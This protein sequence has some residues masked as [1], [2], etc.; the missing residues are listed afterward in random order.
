MPKI[1]IREK[2]NSTAP[3]TASNNFSVVVPG[4]KGNGTYVPVDSSDKGPAYLGYGV[5]ELKSQADF[6]KYIGTYTANYEASGTTVTAPELTVLNGTATGLNKYIKQLTLE[7]FE[8]DLIES[9]GYVYRLTEI[10]SGD[11]LGKNGYLL[12]TVGEKTYE[13]TKVEKASDITDFTVIDPDAGDDFVQTTGAYCKIKPGKEG[14]DAFNEDPHYGNQI[15]YNL[16]GYGYTVLFKVLDSSRSAT[17]QLTESEF[18]APL[19][20]KSVFNFRYLIS[21][22]SYSKDV[23]NQMIQ[24]A[25]FDSTVDL[26]DAEIIGGS[27]TG[28]GDCIALCDID[29]TNIN[30]ADSMENI[31]RGLATAAGAIQASSNA[32]IF[33]PKVQYA[34]DDL[35]YPASYHYLLCSANARKRYAEW[36]AVAGYARGISPI[37]VAGTSLK[38]GEI[39]INT[40][41]PRVK[42]DGLNI[43][44]SINLILN[45]KSSY[46]LWG[47]R[48]AATLD[49]VG[50]VFSHFLNVR[51]LCTSIKKTLYSACRLFTFDPNSDLLWIN[52]VNAIRPTL[53]AMK[54][55]QGIKGY[56]ISKVVHNEKALLK[57][58]IRII[59]I[60]AVEDFDITIYLEDSENGLQV[61]AG[62]Q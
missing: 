8:A 58:K 19:K 39:A 62:E 57:A 33:A 43:Q 52:F 5:Y 18:W 4:Y 60:E 7:D 45:E 38:L 35:V 1:L 26:K 41:A 12:I 40:L 11:D 56:K 24:I 46:Y 20:D 49:G 59:P 32:A 23:M 21:G 50:L 42:N 28:R 36:Y 2:D 9:Q 10:T 16:L 25:D 61:G 44:K 53:E 37:S 6:T 51:Q 34:G 14:K 54:A 22:G 30:S 48:T 27:A 47:N 15:A 13:L 29:E 3:V 55:D 17:S 31:V